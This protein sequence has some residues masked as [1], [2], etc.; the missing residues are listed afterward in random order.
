MLTAGSSQ[1]TSRGCKGNLGAASERQRTRTFAFCV[2]LKTSRQLTRTQT[3]GPVCQVARSPRAT[4]SAHATF[5]KSAP[6]RKKIRIHSASSR[7]LSHQR[8]AYLYSLGLSVS[9]LGP[10][11]S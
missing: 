6:Q 7:S 11:D 10:G 5:F 3:H 1:M 2:L 9:G 8:G 4:A